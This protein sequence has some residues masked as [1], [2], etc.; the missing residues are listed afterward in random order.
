MEAITGAHGGL[1]PPGM[2]GVT[3]VRSTE[4]LESQGK[5]PEPPG[6][7]KYRPPHSPGLGTLAILVYALEIIS[8]SQ[9]HNVSTVI[10]SVLL[11]TFLTYH[12]AHC[13][14]IRKHR[15]FRQFC[16]FFFSNPCNIDVCN[17]PHDGRC[18]PIPVICSTKHFNPSSIS[19]AAISASRDLRWH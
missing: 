10:E 4:G 15:Q 6:R 12:S 8:G 9:T 7:P 5:L 17:G 11:K 13:T 2:F 18:A 16:S 3:T 19:S 1:A 14:W